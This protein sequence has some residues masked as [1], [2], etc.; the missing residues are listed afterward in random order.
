MSDLVVLVLVLGGLE[1][2]SFSFP[3]KIEEAACG[4]KNV[5][6]FLIDLLEI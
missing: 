2:A 5:A 1:I 4:D 3:P 6:L